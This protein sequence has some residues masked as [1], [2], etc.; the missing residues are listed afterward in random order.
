MFSPA[1]CLAMAIYFET[2]VETSYDAGLAVA[3]VILN[4]VDNPK[5]ADTI[6]GVVKEDWGPGKHDCQFSFYCDGKPERPYQGARW[7]RAKQQANE[8]LAGKL[9]PDLQH[10]AL[11]YHAVYVNPSWSSKMISIG[12]IGKHIFYVE[13]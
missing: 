11:F 2:A 9:Q 5:F 12:R 6:C 3:Q 4:R 10:R 8:A 13:K 7:E 1:M